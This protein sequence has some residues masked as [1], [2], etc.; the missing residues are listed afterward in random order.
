M[1]NE[2]GFQHSN[3]QQFISFRIFAIKQSTTPNRSCA[4]EAI[5]TVF[6]QWIFS[7]LVNT[8]AKQSA[9]ARRNS[10]AMQKA[11]H[12][13]VPFAV[14]WTD[15]RSGRDAR[16]I[17]HP[18]KGHE[19]K[20]RWIYGTTSSRETWWQQCCGS[21][22]WIPNTFATLEPKGWYWYFWCWRHWIWDQ[23]SFGW[24]CWFRNYW[25]CTQLQFI[26]AYS[27]R[28]HFRREQRIATSKGSN[29][30]AMHGWVWV[31]LQVCIFKGPI[32]HRSGTTEGFC[33][34]PS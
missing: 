29:P 23:Q 33:Q 4:G 32:Q 14:G 11:C 12:V 28:R 19:Q 2:C 3:Y 6:L 26:L 16:S 17:F 27:Y 24:T 13:T 31:L 5:T 18:S 15:P 25:L 34:R 10:R 9:F 8:A 20:G 21:K 30:T 7:L 1:I 22:G